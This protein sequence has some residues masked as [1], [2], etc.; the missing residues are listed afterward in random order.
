MATSI[1]D[2]DAQEAGDP[3]RV[4]DH[5]EDDSVGHLMKRILASMAHQADA[6]LRPHGLTSAQG[7]PLMRL[8]APDYTTVAEVARSLQIDSGAT[9]RLIDR[10]ERGGLCKRV[11]SSTDRR[12]M[13]VELTREGQVALT[14]VPPV[15]CKVMNEHLAGFS[16]SEWD[17]LKLYLQRMIHNAEAMRKPGTAKAT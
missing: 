9:T 8:S 6:L 7:L 10:L 17:A 3:F 11:R 12:V 5:R 15:L 14:E 13:K 2:R 16:R 1:P 4:V